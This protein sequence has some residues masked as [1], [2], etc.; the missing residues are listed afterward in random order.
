VKRVEKQGYQKHRAIFTSPLLKFDSND[1]VPQLLLTNSH[2]GTSSVIL[3][4]G[5]FRIVCSNGLVVGK[6]LCEPVRIRH[7]APN[8]E[9][10]IEKG[11]EYIVA[12]CAKLNESITKMKAK[13][14]DDEQIRKFQASS[15]AIKFPES[16]IK[17]F[18][19]R[20][21]RTE[22]KKT[23]LFTVF[24]VVQ[25]NLIRGGAKVTIENELNQ[26]VVKRLRKTSSI[27]TQTD[28]NTAL[29]DLA[30]QQLVA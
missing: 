5:F 23:D 16:K 17:D 2:D 8:I 22:D 27:Q 29:W 12:Q 6:Y 20:I 18:E 15:L 10:E 30:E 13:Q 19:F 25:E 3:Q 9:Q 21:N 14:L 1:G 7:T 28:I 4:L 26:D 24:N 11:I